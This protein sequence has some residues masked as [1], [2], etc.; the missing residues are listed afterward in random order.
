MTVD[1]RTAA[2]IVEDALVAVYDAAVV[3]RLREDSPLEALGMSA[4]D[5]ICVADAV[6]ASAVA[7]GHTCVLVDADFADAVTV[8]DL[9]GRVQARADA[10]EAS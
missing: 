1:H 5:A 9:V 3:R 7:A 8:A 4:A 2:A 10:G 6:A